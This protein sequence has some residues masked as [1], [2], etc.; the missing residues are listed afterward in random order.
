[1]DISKFKM[2]NTIL[3]VKDAIARSNIGN[4]ASLATYNKDNLVASINELNELIQNI[5]E[6]KYPVGHYIFSDDCD[7]EEKVILKYGGT[8]WVR[9][10][11]AF[12]AARGDYLAESGGALNQTLSED[13][14]PA[15]SHAQQGNFT[16]GDNDVSH[17]H[18]FTTNEQGAHTHYLSTNIND[19]IIRAGLT[20][21]NNSGG[22]V[23]VANATTIATKSNGAHTHSGTTNT[24]NVKHKHS[25]TLS[26]DTSSVGSGAAFSIVPTY[27][28]AY[29]WRREE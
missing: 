5:Q 9:I 2:K 18:T 4:I 12:I 28:G 11:D 7:T 22:S 8:H 13:N 1:M 15:H 10:Q 21:I 29:C 14:I 26:G 19:N 20:G 23:G 25:L 3:N 24:N 6:S 17:S 27:V 16:T